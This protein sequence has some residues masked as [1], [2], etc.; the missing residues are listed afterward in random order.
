MFDLNQAISEWRRRMI[1]G[2][3]KTTD[4]L[5]ELESHLHADVD[6]QVR[7]GISQ[8]QAFTAAVQRIGES[9]ALKKEFRKVNRH[10]TWKHTV[11][12]ILAAISALIASFLGVASYW[13]FQLT[14]GHY[15]IFK[16]DGTFVYLITARRA[17]FIV[18]YDVGI[19]FLLVWASYA[20]FKRSRRV[21][22]R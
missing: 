1:A 14:D 9:E 4:V 16:T 7:S 18:G 10:K 2:G 8:Q 21:I 5:N 20:M 3:F 11:L 17:Q 22:V 12:K 13:L 19:A 6:E 15:A